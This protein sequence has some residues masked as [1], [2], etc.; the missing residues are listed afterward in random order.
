MRELFTSGCLL[1]LCFIKGMIGEGP[2]TVLFHG[3][4]RKNWALRKPT[5]Q[6]SIMDHYF[7]SDRAV[8]GSLSNDAIMS[9]S[10]M[11]T[12]FETHPWW[13]V[14]LQMTLLVKEVYIMNRGDCCGYRLKHLYI[15]V[16]KGN[17]AQ[18]HLVGLCHY[19]R[20][21]I[22][23]GIA[24]SFRCL[25]ELMGQFVRLSIHHHSYTEY[26]ISMCEVEV[27]GSEDA[28]ML[29]SKGKN[30]AR[31]ATASQS[32]THANSGLSNANNAI[33]GNRDGVYITGSCSHTTMGD[34]RPWWQVE[35]LWMIMVTGVKLYNR[36][37]CCDERLHDFVITVLQNS[38]DTAPKQ[39]YK[40]TTA[41]AKT[42]TITCEEPLA[43][44]IVR[45]A[46]TRADRHD[47]VLTLC[48]VEVHGWKI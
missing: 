29:A 23:S 10:C 4:E 21:S 9:R 37:D 34:Y 33:D 45:V 30:W 41:V 13:M 32:S 43:G 15:E 31:L 14:D 7:T 2:S 5:Y 8:D 22:T 20:E 39:C 36:V 28:Y 24:K 35:L 6:S 16:Y 12:Q 27:Y 18:L 46:K 38:H 44:W 1:L 11:H 42:A 26:S 47:D 25:Y 3:R 19:Q 17:I 40:Q 48:E